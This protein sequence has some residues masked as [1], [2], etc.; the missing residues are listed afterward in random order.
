MYQEPNSY[1]E[2]DQRLLPVEDLI[3][4]KIILLHVENASYCGINEKLKQIELIREKIIVYMPSGNI[5]CYLMSFAIPLLDD[6][7]SVHLLTINFYVGTNFLIKQKLQYSI[8]VRT[9]CTKKNIT[10]TLNY[11]IAFNN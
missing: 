2:K 10:I 6:L 4:F 3:N 11:I 9:P 8:L 7:P 5:K 1:I